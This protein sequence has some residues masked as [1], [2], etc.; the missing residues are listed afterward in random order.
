MGEKQGQLAI[1][2]DDIKK[3]SRNRRGA[4]IA[5]A[6]ERL[7]VRFTFDEKELPARY[8]KASSTAEPKQLQ[9]DSQQEL[10]FKAHVEKWTQ[11][12][13]TML[14][15]I[16]Q[17]QAWRFIGLSPKVDSTIRQLTDCS[18]FCDFTDYLILRRDVENCSADELGGLAALSVAFQREIEKSLPAR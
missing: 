12:I 3:D 4:R 17:Q 5:I 11:L 9:K 15:K 16:D 14:G 8:R 2:L 13:E 1:E 7:A 10:R 6:A 18:D